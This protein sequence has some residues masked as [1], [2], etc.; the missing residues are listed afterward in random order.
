VSGERSSTTRLLLILVLALSVFLQSVVV[1]RTQVNAPLRVDA[2]DYFSY[3]LNLRDHGVYSLQRGWMQKDAPPPVPD[4]TRPPGYPVFLLLLHPAKSWEWLTKLGYVQS[5]LATFSVLLVFLLGRR[6]LADG[7]ALAA[8]FLTAVCP[9]LVV[10]PTYVL[11][12]TLFTLLLLLAVLATSAS[13][14]RPTDWRFAVLTGLA[15]AAS[16]LVRPTSQFLPLLFL[17][18]AM[19]LPALASLR[20]AAAW[21]LLAFVLA[22]APWQLRNQSLPPES[23]G[24]SLMVKALAHGSYPDFKFE[25]RD[26]SYGYPYHSDPRAEERARNLPSFARVLAA[27]VQQ[28]PGRMLRWYLVGKPIAFLSWADPQSWDIFIYAVDRSPYLENAWLKHS[29]HL[30]RVLHAPLAL[31]ATLATLIAL[32]RPRLLVPEAGARAAMM[33]VA[34][35]FAYAIAFHMVVAPFP[36]YNLP[37]RPLMFLLAALALQSGWRWLAAHG[38]RPAPAGVAGRV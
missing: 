11:S 26:D 35:V 3:A 17:L 12:E 22:L 9:S 21:C 34:V 1:S 6:F 10:M 23:G 19:A 5:L 27:D 14:R 2:L 24:S 30:M 33:L 4:A 28:H 37:F 38:A 15:W 8:A 36:R 13:L 18:L 16:A 29:W 7:W 25:G 31:L 32:W 20:R